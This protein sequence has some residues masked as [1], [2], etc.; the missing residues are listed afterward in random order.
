MPDQTTPTTPKENP[1]GFETLN[2]YVGTDSLGVGT[3]IVAP[4]MKTAC[5]VYEDQVKEDPTTMQC[6]KKEI[7]CVLPD[8]YVSFETLVEDPS[9]LAANTC[10]ATPEKYTLL[11]GSKQVFT[12]SAGEG[13]KF[14]RWTIDGAPVEGD[15]GTKAVAMLE[16]PASPAPIKIVAEF[17][18][19]ITV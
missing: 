12:A 3:T 1:I 11:A 8:V 9:G 7:R 19:D 6:T 13:W 2:Q 4:D 15:E 10:K 5:A 14:V 18:Q 17:E 16:I